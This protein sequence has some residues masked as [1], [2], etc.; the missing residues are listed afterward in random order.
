MR[1][2]DY[3]DVAILAA[4]GA[5]SLLIFCGSARANEWTRAVEVDE[6]AVTI[7]TVDRATFTRTMREYG[8]KP[9]LGSVGFSVLG[10]L[11][12]AWTCY[13][14]V[15]DHRDRETIEHELRHCHGWVHE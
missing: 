1:R 12:G 10:K 5:I 13:V 8:H 14:Y 2:R 4:A 6:P 11:E 7:H 9:R 3:W 15:L